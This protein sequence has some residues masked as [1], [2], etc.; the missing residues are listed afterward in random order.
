MTLGVH[1]L[2]RPTVHYCNFTGCCSWPPGCA[3]HATAA[4]IPA[5]LAQ[6]CHVFRLTFFILLLLL[7]SRVDH[8]ASVDV[9]IFPRSATCLRRVHT[10]NDVEHS[11]ICIVAGTARD[12]CTWMRVMRDASD[13]YGC[14]GVEQGIQI[15]TG[16]E[17]EREARGRGGIAIGDVSTRVSRFEYRWNTDDTDDTTRPFTMLRVGLYRDPRP[18]LV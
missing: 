11:A 14:C 4:V 16:R 5:S 15:R 18:L 12:G 7:P 10:V 8:V 2:T 1:I 3:A 9:D 6:T 13:A 17:R